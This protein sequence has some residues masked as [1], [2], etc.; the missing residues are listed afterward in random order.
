MAGPVSR[1]NA[2]RS[3]AAKMPTCAWSGRGGSA[4][5]VAGTVPAGC[6]SARKRRFAPPGELSDSFEFLAWSE[7]IVEQ[8]V[9]W[10]RLLIVVAVMVIVVGGVAGWNALKAH[11]IRKFMAKNAARPQTVSTMTVGYSTWQP[12]VRAVGSLRAVHGV[13]ISPQVAGMVVGV[14]FKSGSYAHAGQVLVRLNDAP[15]IAKLHSLQATAHFDLLTYQRDVIQYRAQAIGKA[16]L[17]A[18]TADWKSAVAQVKQQQALIAEETVRAPFAGRL[19]ITT[20]NPG[21]YLQAGTS[22]VSLESLD[23]I[24]DDFMLPQGDLARIHLGQKV[25]VHT[26][27]FPHATFIGRISSTDSRVDPSTRNFEAE[28][29]IANPRRLLRPG[30]FVRT[31]VDSG[32][33]RR[34]LTVPQTAISYAPY[35]DTVFIVHPGKKPGGPA[36]VELAFVTLGPTR[37]DQIAVVKGL[38]AGQIIVTSGQLKLKNGMAVAINNS[39]Q[40]LNN[41]NP[42]PQEQ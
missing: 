23:P 17:D 6:G 29:T 4:G 10:R 2:R 36:T 28:A 31:V 15:D 25:E 38:K 7:Q 14:E 42:S 22:V 16:T 24:F 5:S 40:P 3:I 34:Y 35:G 27:A 39:V 30:M 19:G 20:V 12:H 21:Q 41:P 26:R 8:R 11:Y 1:P 13:E 37:G 32:A 18:A 33:K 9:M